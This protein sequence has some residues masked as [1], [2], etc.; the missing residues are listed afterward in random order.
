MFARF[1]A[2]SIFLAVVI[3][4]SPAEEPSKGSKATPSDLALEINALRT[5][6]Y[7]KVTPEQA[8]TLLKLSKETVGPAKKRKKSKLTADYRRLMEEVR[9]ALAD[10]EEERVETLEDQL[11]EKTIRECPDIDDSVD[12]TDA[13][14]KHA[15]KVVRMLR[16]QQAALFLGTYAEQIPDPRVD[17]LEAV[18]KVRDWSLAEWQEK[19]DVLGD[20]ISQLAAGA[21][22]QKVIKTRDAVIDLLAHARTMKDEEY[23][24]KRGE[25]EIAADKIVG[26]SGPTEVLRNFLENE[27]ARL[28]SNPRLEAAL[29]AR[30]K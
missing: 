7:L 15:P 9:D 29:R 27:L 13:A 30:I 25:L 10:D 18:M 11:E 24:L 23:A 14:R 12:M 3:S 17:L 21:D 6:Y 28:L 5:L 20:E 16:A 8:E 4:S 22:K 19:R 1:I 26:H 2:I